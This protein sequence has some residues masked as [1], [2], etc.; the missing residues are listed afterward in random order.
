MS[1]GTFHMVKDSHPAKGPIVVLGSLV[2]VDSAVH[3][4]VPIAEC[5][6]GVGVT[7]SGKIN[8][9]LTVNGGT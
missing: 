7:R 5:S 4:D 6:C 3:C 1:D 2:P 8:T 9:L